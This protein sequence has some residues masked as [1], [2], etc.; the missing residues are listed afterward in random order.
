MIK[1]WT[2]D[3]LKEAVKNSLSYAAVFRKL[4]LSSSGNALRYLKKFCIN[5]NISTEHFTGRNWTKGIN[6]IPTN[7]KSLDKI[8]TV[9]SIYPSTE[10]RKRLISEGFKKFECENCKLIE[11]MGLPIGL[12]L[13][14]INGINTD[15][16][17]ENLRILCLN[18]HYQTPTW[19]GKKID[20]FCDCGKKLTNRKSMKCKK[21]HSNLLAEKAKLQLTKRPN[22]EILELQIWKNPAT[23]LAEIYNVS[24]RT[25]GKW[26][27]YYNIEKPPKGYWIKNA[28]IY[29]NG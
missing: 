27:K 25:I 24:D 22:K 21:C 17:I 1:T 3:E 7:K 26:C 11:W 20:R 13:D 2:D 5:N 18:C 29:A 4:N 28:G 15:N 16:R 6:F 23:K 12:Q 14:H 8:L 9:D 10:L 19:G